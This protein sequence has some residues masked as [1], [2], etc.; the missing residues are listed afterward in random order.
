MLDRGDASTVFLFGDAASATLVTSQ[1][2]GKCLKLERPVCLASADP[3]IAIHL[4]CL[5]TSRSLRMDGIAVART[6]YKAMA[7]AVR[8]ASHQTGITS[9]DISTL[10]PHPG[11]TRI[12]RN[13]AD[14]LGF[15]AARVLTTLADT[16]NTSSSSIPLAIDRY[17]DRLPDESP[18]ALTAFGA[19]FTSAATLARRMGEV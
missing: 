12:L 19:G 11:S 1:P 18:I 2:R 5:G 17:W 7:N 10:I 8:E 14:S 9:S 15:D 4:P 16:G 3:D 13:V 6:A